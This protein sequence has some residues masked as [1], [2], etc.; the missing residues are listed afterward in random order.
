MATLRRTRAARRSP[1]IGDRA[2]SA[3]RRGA[4]G[5]ARIVSLIT[6]VVVGLI[7]IGIVLV[8][9]EANR[10][11]SIVNWLVD[12]AHWLVG[13]FDDVFEPDGRKARV[14]VNWGL[15]AVLYAIVGGFI[16]RLLRR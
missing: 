11:N 9:L 3:A 10:D 14:A 12:A 16:A 2:G 1:G 4:W 7:V 13:P 6:S 8:L 5:L 15:A